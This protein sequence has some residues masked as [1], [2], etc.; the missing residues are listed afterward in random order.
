MR[1]LD[2]Y[3]LREI[4]V[5]FCV[6]MSLFFVVVAFAQVLK[7]SDTVTGLSVTGF[8][9]LQAL[10]Y[11]FPPLM[12]LLIP[13]S[14]LFATLLAVGRMSSDREII[15]MSAGGRSPLQLLGIPAVTGVLLAGV[16]AWMLIYGEPWGVRGLNEVFQQSAQRAL[17][18]GVRVGKFNEWVSGVT[19]M[20][21]GKEG[22][23]LLEVVFADRRDGERP[24]VISARRGKV[25]AGDNTSD[26]IFDLK[27]GAIVLH[28]QKSDLIRVLRF[29]ESRYRLDVGR[30]V[31][32]RPKTV[33]NLQHMT[34]G[35]LLTYSQN[36]DKSRKNRVRATVFLHRKIALPIATL[37][38][39]LLAVPLAV[40][41]TSSARARG[42]L[43][44]A[45]IVGTYYYLGRAVEMAAR[46]GNFPALLAAWVPDI[47][48]IIVFAILATRMK[49][50]FA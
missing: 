2:R 23:E 27:D 3:L 6:G 9:I 46:T 36:P 37:V 14:L 30:L 34:M 50:G 18:S 25:A 22:D 39:A 32:K 17:A 49:R 40:G 13:V 1:T 28:D 48:G 12:G 29:D 21:Q 24:I 43:Y 31:N 35:Q 26:I 47:I 5:P 11:S 19:F 20:A 44:S 8:E 33:S 38:F 15:A 42:F 41:G 4:T 16:C 45:G 10:I 7:V